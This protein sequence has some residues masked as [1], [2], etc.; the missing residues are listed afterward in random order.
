MRKLV[1]FALGF[2][3]GCALLA[4]RILSVSIPLFLS[5]TFLLAA[6]WILAGRQERMQIAVYPV[7]GCL[8]SPGL[9]FL[10]D[11]IW[12]ILMR[13]TEKRNPYPLFCRI[14]VKQQT[15][16]QR[17]TEFLR[18]TESRIRFACIWIGRIFFLRVQGSPVHSAF[19]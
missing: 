5:L 16:E 7:L 11:G 6:V 9:A 15:M 10:K 17:P 4:Y 2:C 8:Y 13:F 12:Q 3:A 1:Y 18:G 19:A 14:S